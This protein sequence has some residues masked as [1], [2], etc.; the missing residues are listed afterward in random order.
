MRRTAAGE[1]EE[2]VAVTVVAA[3]TRD[4]SLVAGTSGT[5]EGEPALPGQ[6][7]SSCRPHHPWRKLA[8]L[9]SN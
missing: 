1:E 5:V 9:T 3:G 7:Y 8:I 4:K 2:A 6:G